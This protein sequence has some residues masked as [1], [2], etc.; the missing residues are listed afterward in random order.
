MTTDGGAVVFVVAVPEGSLEALAAVVAAERRVE[1][2]WLEARR[3]ALDPGL[4][5]RQLAAA[6]R[7]IRA[8]RT[9]RRSRGD[10]AG[11]RDLVLTRSLRV[12]LDRRGL[13]RDWPEPPAGALD[14]PGR[15]T[16]H[17]VDTDPDR[18]GPE[19]LQVRLSVELAATVRRA[20]YWVSADPIAKLQDWADRWGDGPQVQ[21]EQSARDGVPAELALFAAAGAKR[22][23]ADALLERARLRAAVVTTGDLV[24]EALRHALDSRRWP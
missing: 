2:E 3:A 9:A 19:R 22:P 7:E 23:T 17:S 1:E 15:R 6:R 12:V 24:R 18:G 14:A 13:A 4:T 16:G 20:A 8:E 21:L 11:N 5:T 10:F